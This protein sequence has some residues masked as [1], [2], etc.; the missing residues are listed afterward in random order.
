VATNLAFQAGVLADPE[1]A[2]GSVDTG[3]VARHLGR[4]ATGEVRHG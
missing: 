3:F 1:F 2:A 4:C